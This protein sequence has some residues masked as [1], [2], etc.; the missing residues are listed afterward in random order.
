[1][2]GW[3][4]PTHVEVPPL[5]SMPPAKKGKRGTKAPR[6]TGVQRAPTSSHSKLD[7]L[8]MM[9]NTLLRLEWKK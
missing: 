8:L 4:V 3:V 6:K 2:V 9:G 5:V 7:N 1:M